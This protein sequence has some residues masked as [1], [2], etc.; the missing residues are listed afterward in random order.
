VRSCYHTDKTGGR[1]GS[2]IQSADYYNG[3][4]GGGQNCHNEYGDMVADVKTEE[5]GM[6]VEITKSACQFLKQL[7]KEVKT[8][9]NR[10][11]ASPYYYAVEEDEEIVGIDTG[12]TDD[13][14][15]VS[16]DG[17]YRLTF[18]ELVASGDHEGMPTDELEAEEWLEAHGW[19]K[20]GVLTRSRY[21]NVFLTEKAV[22]EHIQANHYHY[23]NPRDFLFFAGR[24]PEMKCL[25]ETV[26]EVGEA[27]AAMEA[28][29]TGLITPT[30]VVGDGSGCDAFEREGPGQNRV[31][32]YVQGGPICIAPGEQEDE[33]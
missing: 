16:E 22:R 13:V 9:D 24:N 10:C 3:G 2:I 32:A 19:E 1:N 21:S 30:G 31:I 25:I 17:E 14:R 15:W 26:V 12:W 29:R 23:K 33:G 8:Q 6:K 28:E 27:I 20:V 4:F 7:A 11:T 18:D 5:A